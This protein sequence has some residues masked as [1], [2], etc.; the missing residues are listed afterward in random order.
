MRSTKIGL[1]L[2][3]IAVSLSVLSNEAVA[4]L[5]QWQPAGQ[6]SVAL[7]GDH[8]LAA[9]S[10]RNKSR[11]LQIAIEPKA[12]GG[13]VRLHF[14]TDGEVE[15][16]GNSQADIALDGR[17]WGAQKVQ[18][19]PSEQPHHIIYRW[20]FAASNLAEFS[21]A[22]SLRIS[23][24]RLR[25]DLPISHLDSA[26]ADLHE[27]NSKLLSRWGFGPQLQSRVGKF[28]W[29]ENAADIKSSD[30]PASAI[31]RRAIGGPDLDSTTCQL[32]TSRA[33]FGSAVDK[34]GKA[35]AA[36]YYFQ[37]MWDMR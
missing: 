15:E 2:I 32:M 11:Q 33:R 7:Q 25:A 10:F 30:Y 16:Y 37:F 1:R 21:A 19:V 34:E 23:A 35:M 31:K 5:P 24:G 36:P 14:V 17:R 27:C 22:Q 26:A 8:C 13:W 4:G 29:L 20:G 3:G 6:W 18:V 9:L 12:T 28:P